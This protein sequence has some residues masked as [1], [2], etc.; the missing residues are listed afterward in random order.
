MAGNKKDAWSR[1]RDREDE[2]DE[3]LRREVNEA[4]GEGAHGDQPKIVD[5][6]KDDQAHHEH[7][8]NGGHFDPAFAS[9]DSSKLLVHYG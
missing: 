7:G 2:R 1:F 3:T 9:E 5:G 4:L 8:E 6:Q